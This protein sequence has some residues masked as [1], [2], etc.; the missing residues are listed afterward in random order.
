M[1]PR[2]KTFGK[3]LLSNQT[4]VRDDKVILVNNADFEV[5]Y[6]K[7]IKVRNLIFYETSRIFLS[8]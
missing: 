2:K 3:Y 1:L 4:C 7:V 8:T 6:N 5:S